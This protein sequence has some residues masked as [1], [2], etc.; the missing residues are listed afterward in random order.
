MKDAVE[1]SRRVR[2]GA[3]RQ[4][5]TDVLCYDLQPADG[6]PLPPFTPGAHVDVQVPNGLVRQYS[7][8]GNPA[9]AGGVYR[10]AVKK[11]EGGR[12]GSRGMHEFVEVGSAL[13][14]VGP[15]NHFP[16]VQ[17]GAKH[18]FIA[19]GI[20]VTPIHAMAQFLSAQG[21][22]WA[23]H[24]CAR[25][26][27]HAAFHEE[28]RALPGGTVT[29]HFSEVPTLDV[30]ALLRVQPEGT[31]VYC[32]GPQGLMKAVESATA[33]WTPGHAHFE[34]FA[35]PAGE[36]PPNQPIEVE[37]AKSGRTYGVPANRSILH[38]L[39]ENGVDIPCACEEGVCGSCETAVLGG[40][41]QHRDLLLSP[42][43]RAANRSMMVCVSRANS[44]RL[45]LDL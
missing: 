33:H 8:C 11:E 44:R 42:E 43:E 40:E 31:H 16:L 9:D 37:L 34:W 6:R 10:I 1:E 21:K 13:G 32:C 39:R 45:V 35:A 26:A 2:V 15:R 5:G 7:L 25:S 4:V 18:L 24:Y 22:P 38:V 20:G 19:G 36:W 3:I 17:D 23:L 41:P 30:A 14:I 29:P 12:G 28:L 27:E